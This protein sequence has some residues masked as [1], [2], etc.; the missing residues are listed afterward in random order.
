[1]KVPYLATSLCCFLV[2]AVLFGQGENLI[3]KKTEILA[4]W[5]ALA[6]KNKS[7]RWEERIE[8]YIATQTDPSALKV[9][10]VDVIRRSI[11]SSQGSSWH[12]I[13]E[14]L[15]TVEKTR[16]RNS[17]ET[18]QVTNTRYSA[19]L[20]KKLKNS[21]WLISEI[22]QDKKTTE[23]RLD[24][25]SLFPWTKIGNVELVDFMAEPKFKFTRTE[26]KPVQSGAK[27]LRCYFSHAGASSGWLDDI[28]GGYVDFQSETPYR[29]FA[30]RLDLKNATSA[31]FHTGILEYQ[32]S[33]SYP[34][35]AKMTLEFES[36]TNKKG[37]V[38]GKEI[39]SF[40]KTEIGPPTIPESEFR[41]SHYGL[42][43]PAGVVWERPT[44]W[45]LWFVA[46]A[47]MSVSI[48]W[49]LRHRVERRKIIQADVS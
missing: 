11:I 47:I 5:K 8:Y 34:I 6:K 19:N 13:S 30:Y 2:P 42:P 12:V 4:T 24:V 14:S 31:G 9:T 7:I 26:Q 3:E 48:G 41:L 28:Q 35:L 36:R 38:F 15:S 33:D 1:M 18:V 20:K 16:A 46:G 27:I 23:E 39:H 37:H 17:K 49:Y 21:D 22:A 44:P 29:P 45:Y 40:S 25:S 43:E 10:H 32:D